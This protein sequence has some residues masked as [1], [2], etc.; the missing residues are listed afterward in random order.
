MWIGI[1]V[2][3]LFTCFVGAMVSSRKFGDPSSGVIGFVIFSSVL[4]VLLYNTL[5]SENNQ[6]HTASIQAIAND[7]QIVQVIDDKPLIEQVEKWENGAHLTAIARESFSNLPSY[8]LS[9]VK[10]VEVQPGHPDLPEKS[11]E[12][13]EKEN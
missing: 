5:V 12:R 4:L 10:V 13:A 2:V 9:N 8:H 3:C 11:K 7:W 6:N 1:C